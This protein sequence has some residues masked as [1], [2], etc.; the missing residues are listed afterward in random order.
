MGLF[1]KLFK[2]KKRQW[3]L[4]RTIWHLRVQSTPKKRGRPPKNP[5]VEVNQ[6]TTNTPSE[7]TSEYCSMNSSLAYSNYYFGLNIFDIFSQ[8][9][10]ADLV[11]DPNSRCNWFS[12]SK[13]ISHSI[14]DFHN[15]RQ[16]LQFCRR[17]FWVCSNT[18]YKISQFFRYLKHFCISRSIYHIFS[19]FLSW[20][21]GRVCNVVKVIIRNANCFTNRSHIFSSHF[22]PSID[23]TICFL[24]GPS[25]FFCNK[26]LFN[27]V[28]S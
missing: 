23:D 25:T 12:W 7:V 26:N 22:L 18:A 27:S 5:V 9:Q 28:R 16:N 13:L 24:F 19:P 15:L 2:R 10:L 11:R 6:N 4:S 17:G 3:V 21:H 1:S 14:Q 20:T 8:E